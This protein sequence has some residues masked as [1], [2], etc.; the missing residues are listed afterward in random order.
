[1]NQPRFCQYCGSPMESDWQFC[2]HCG[3][4]PAVPDEPAPPPEA[5]PTVFHPPVQA[6][7]A[8]T[9]A[10][11]R[12]PAPK[13]PVKSAAPPKRSLAWLLPV[14]VGCVALVCMCLFVIAGYFFL[15]RPAS[16][17]QAA[18]A[19]QVAEI[20][21]AATE[22]PPQPDTPAETQPSEPTDWPTAAA[23]TETPWP[24]A[25]PTEAPSPTP[26]DQAFTGKQYREE[27]AIFDDFSSTALGWPEYNDGITVLQYED[28]AYSFQINEG[29]YYDWVYA[30]VDF[31]PNAIQFEVWGEPGPQ[32]GTFGVMCQYQD[33]NNYYY[34]EIDLGTREFVM[35]VNR[36]GEHTPLTIP[37]EYGQYWLS[38]D[39]LK[40]YPEDINRIDLTC[41]QDFMVLLINTGLVYHANIPEPF[42]A[43]G[44]IAFFVYANPT[45]G[46]EGYRVFFDNVAVQRVPE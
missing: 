25:E 40:A 33:E 7:P 34:V 29:D 8:T 18:T 43:P 28:G 42:T 21:P 2:E 41:Y 1:M 5:A 24:T 15:Q 35:A 45:V 10:P 36:N 3:G 46:V 44:E 14:G 11:P 26:E 38:A 32:E 4:Q 23:P 19:T 16:S 37:D 27:E 9:Q 13:Q 12:T 39:P 17:S 20:L 31:W 6:P 22:V 30:P